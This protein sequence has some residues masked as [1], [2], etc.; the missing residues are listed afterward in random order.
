M[1]RR[2][3]RNNLRENLVLTFKHCSVAVRISLVLLFSVYVASG[4]QHTFA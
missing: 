2:V 1:G 3:G 4:S